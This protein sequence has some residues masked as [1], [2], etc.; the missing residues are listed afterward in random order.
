M[1]A[2]A[3]RQHLETVLWGCAL[4]LF[5]L[6]GGCR[7]ENSSAGTSTESAYRMRLAVGSLFTYDHWLLDRYG[8]KVPG[9]RMRRTWLVLAEGATAE[10]LSDVTVVQDSTTGQ[11]L[12]TLLFRFT[13]SGDVHL[14]GYVSRMIKRLQGRTI[15]PAWDL[16][17][18]FSQGLSSTWIVGTADSLGTIRAVGQTSGQELL[19][20]VVVNGVKTVFPAYQ[21][22]VWTGDLAGS[23]WPSTSPSAFVSL[24][25]ETIAPS[26]S[27]GG[28]LNELLEMTVP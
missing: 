10:G 15:P 18:Q 1:S 12:D 3:L 4:S 16:I 23:F 19:F 21:V 14:F 26:D 9:S 11:G 2:R 20:E 8:D 6:C 22:E 17:V 27:F 25:E 28:E 7:E 13:P 5:C 24:S